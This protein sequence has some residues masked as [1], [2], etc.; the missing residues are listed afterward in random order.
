MGIVVIVIIA[1][2]LLGVT[3]NYA[4][5]EEAKK[6]AIEQNIR[7]HDAAYDLLRFHAYSDDKLNRS[8]IDIIAAYMQTILGYVY[9]AAAFKKQLAVNMPGLSTVPVHIVSVQEKLTR[10]EIDV[11]VS[12]IEMLRG[13]KKRHAPAV[14]QWYERTLRDLRSTPSATPG[15]NDL[16]LA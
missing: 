6:K 12:H 5:K 13:T 2:I 3:M 4:M 10:Q 14:T 9:D 16:R 15:I 11:L 7:R 8:E 1:A